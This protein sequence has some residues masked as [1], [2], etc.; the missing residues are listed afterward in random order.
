MYLI[1]DN[2]PEF[3]GTKKEI[4]DYI[5]NSYYDDYYVQQYGNHLYKN[6]DAL[7][8]TLESLRLKITHKLPKKKRRAK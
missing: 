6:N 7:L 3:T 2:L 1:R 8:Q 5:L 4:I